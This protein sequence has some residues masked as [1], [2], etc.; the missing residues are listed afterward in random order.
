VVGTVGAFSGPEGA[1]QAGVPQ[2]INAWA[3]QVNAA[4]GI[5]GHQ[6]KVIVK[7]IG[8]NP[9]GGLAAVQ[10]L[11]QSDHVVAIVGEEDNGDGSW[12][13]YAE[14]SGVPVVGG[15]SLDLPFVQN[16][17][18]FPAGSNTFALVYGVQ[19]LAKG[20][21][22]NLGILYC[23]ESPQCASSVTLNQG[24][25]QVSGVKIPVNIKISAT[26]PDYT[27]V[28][29]QLKSS[30]VQSYFVA[31]NSAVVL[32]VAGQ[33]K[34]Q[35]LA[36]T[37]VGEDGEATAAW[38]AQSSVNG[39]LLA[40]ADAPFT[41]T[42]IPGV[43]QY[44]D[45]VSKYA[46]SLGN[47]QGPNAFYAYVAGKLFQAAVAA[48]PAGTAITPQTVKQGLYALKGATLDGLTPPLTYTE[49]KP[50]LVNCFFTMG[51]QNGKFTSP[52]GTKT[53]CAPDA[54]VNAIVSSLPKQ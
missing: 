10:E 29:Q 15:L 40:E 42:S 20:L 2:V 35:G 4:G 49:G 33:C 38:Q 45:A 8:S 23:A 39:M 44:Q 17:D 14:S 6:V 18:F 28:C 11:V 50:T 48:L 36:A 27:A 22:P 3:S 30:G 51:L 26:A 53:T 13:S 16:P 9:T 19:T 24:T 5:A 37:M 1:S 52:N 46:P 7:D 47:L 54:F 43:A 21:G 31:D 34:A 41:D 32:R 25:A 12:A